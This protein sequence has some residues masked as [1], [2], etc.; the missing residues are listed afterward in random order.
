MVSLKR[1]STFT[2]HFEES[3]CSVTGG[4]PPK[5]QINI[6]IQ[7]NAAGVSRLSF[8]FFWLS[9]KL[10]TATSLVKCWL[11]TH[12][13]GSVVGVYFEDWRFIFD[14]VSKKWDGRQFWRQLQLSRGLID[15]SF[16]F[17]LHS[18]SSEIERGP[19]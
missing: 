10:V 14:N 6:K 13:L 7:L 8:R 15:E 18:A 19:F 2:C 1:I 11:V 12:P 9:L 17:I 4:I 3:C 16:I 5:F